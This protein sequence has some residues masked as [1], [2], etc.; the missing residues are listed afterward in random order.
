MNKYDAVCPVPDIGGDGVV[1]L[2]N[3]DDHHLDQYR[4]RCW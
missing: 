1:N 3:Q 2:V 4:Y